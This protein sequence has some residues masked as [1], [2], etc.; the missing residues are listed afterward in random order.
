MT[1]ATITDTFPAALTS[2]SWTCAASGGSSCGS[3]S[4]SGNLNTTANLLAGGTVTY[5]V[6]ATVSCV[7]DGFDHEHGDGGGAGWCDRNESD[8]QHRDAMWIRRT[9]RWTWR[10]ARRMV[11]PPSCLARR[12]RTRSWRRTMDRVSRMARTITDTF[13]AFLVNPTWTCA[14]SVGSSCGAA[15]GT[16]NMNTT[17]NLLVGGTATYTVNATVS[18]VGVGCASEHGDGGG[19][20]WRD[21][22]ESGEQHRDRC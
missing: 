21:R 12:S 16:G 19:A 14:A 22:N 3:A 11:W 18:R 10:S 6:N 5:T 17:V 15:S 9:R 1:G 20:G 2:V 4:G 7:G 8:E 13:P